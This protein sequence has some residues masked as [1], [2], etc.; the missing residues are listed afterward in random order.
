MPDVLKAS[1]LVIGFH[2]CDL[3][4]FREVVCDGGSLNPSV[5]DYDWL[6]SGIYFWEQ[7]YERAL[8]RAEEQTARGRIE[9][10]AAVGAIID[11]GYC[12]TSSRCC[13]DVPKP[14]FW[15]V[16]DG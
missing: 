6:G 3:S 14:S 12:L 15:R 1:S 9:T 7:N 10:P 11:L 4:T 8:Q 5:N 13:D 2:G 16:G